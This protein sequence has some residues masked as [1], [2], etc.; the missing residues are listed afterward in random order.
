[1]TT[2]SELHNGRQWSN[3]PI[4][5]KFSP[6]LRFYSNPLNSILSLFILSSWIVVFWVDMEVK[7]FVDHDD[8]VEELNFP[9]RKMKLVYR[10]GFVVSDA[11]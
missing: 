1:M 9:K 7:I 8:G 5:V 6:E 4:P 2:E 11:R 3:N 10:I